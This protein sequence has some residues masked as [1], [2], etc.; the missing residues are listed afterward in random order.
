[1]KL[2]IFLVL[3]ALLLAFNS[4]SFSQTMNSVTPT[5]S[6]VTT[7]TTGYNINITTTLTIP[8]GGY[9]DIDLSAPDVNISL[10]NGK[11]VTGTFAGTITSV[12]GD[13]VRIHITSQ[14]TAGTYNI[15]LPDYIINGTA[16]NDSNVDWT[17][18]GTDGITVIES[19]VAAG[20]FDITDHVDDSKSGFSNTQ[21]SFTTD[22]FAKI[23]G[24]TGAVLPALVA[25]DYVDITFPAGFDVSSLA[26]TQTGGTA[27]KYIG[28]AVQVNGQIVRAILANAFAPADNDFLLLSRKII[29]PPTVTTYTIKVRVYDVSAGYYVG[30]GNF[31]V[32][33]IAPYNVLNFI[34][35][36]A[37]GDAVAFGD[38]D[39]LRGAT[40]NGE[41]YFDL[42]THFEIPGNGTGA[43]DYKLKLTFPNGFVLADGAIISAG[44]EFQEGATDADATGQVYT[45]VENNEDLAIGTHAIEL[46]DIVDYPKKPGTY[47][48]QTAIYVDTLGSDVLIEEGS[49]LFTVY[50][51][52]GI[53]AGTAGNDSINGK[54]IKL[55]SY[56]EGATNVKYTF[57]LDLSQA[58]ISDGQI[59]ITFPAAAYINDFADVFG[60]DEV[61]E[62]DF[63]GAG[64]AQEG[65]IG[66]TVLTIDLTDI[67]GIGPGRKQLILP[68][69]TDNGAASGVI[70]MYIRVD[71]LGAD[72]NYE[73]FGKGTF[74]LTEPLTISSSSDYQ[75]A[76]AI[77]TFSMSSVADLSSGDYA[78]VMFPFE[79]N[80]GSLDG[81]TAT[82]TY[83]GAITAENDT[84]LRITIS[85][86]PS[87]GANTINLPLGVQNPADTSSYF[88]TIMTEDSDSLQ[89][90]MFG[91]N[92]QITASPTGELE[93]TGI[94]PTSNLISTAN[95]SYTITVSTRIDLPVNS[96]IEIKFPSGYS[97]FS[98]L[99]RGTITDAGSEFK[100]MITIVDSSSSEVIVRMKLNEEVAAGNND[101]I[102]PSGIVNPGAAGTYSISMRTLNSSYVELERYGSRSVSVTADPTSFLLS[103]ISASSAVAGA[104]NVTYTLNFVTQFPVQSANPDSIQVIFPFGFRIS[105]AGKGVSQFA[106]GDVNP[107]KVSGDSMLSFEAIS[108]ISSGQ[109]I[110]KITGIT[111]PIKTGTYTIKV[112]TIDEAGI[113][114]ESNP[115]VASNTITM[116]FTGQTVSASFQLDST[117]T[118]LQGESF[119]FKFK[120]AYSPGF[121]GSAGWS[122]WMHTDSDLLAI[123][124]SNG[125]IRITSGLSTGSGSSSLQTTPVTADTKILAEGVPYYLYATLPAS[126]PY[127]DSTKVAVSSQA[128]TVR[129]QPIVDVAAKPIEPIVNA[130]LNSGTATPSNTYTI[131]WKAVDYNNSSIDVKL[132]LAAADSLGKSQITQSNSVVT[133]LASA[134]RI[135][136]DAAI[137]K[138]TASYTLN[139]TSPSIISRGTYYVYITVHDG[140]NYNI[141]RSAGTLIVKHA[142]AIS[143]DNPGSTGAEVDTIKTNDQLAVPIFWGT[144]G[145][146]DV[147]N[148]EPSISLYLSTTNT[149]DYSTLTGHESTITLTSNISLDQ[150]VKNSKSSTLFTMRLDFLKESGNLPTEGTEY[151]VYAVISD[152]TDYVLSQSETKLIFTYTPSFKFKA[153]FGGSAA[154]AAKTALGDDRIKLRKG[155]K[156]QVDFEAYDLDAD[157]QIRLVAC[158]ISNL[159]AEDF[160][161][162]FGGAYSYGASSWLINSTDGT[163]GIGP[164]DPNTI[165]LTTNDSSYVWDTGNMTGIVDGNYYIYALVTND[166]SPYEWSEDSTEV[167]V[168]G[169]T[170]NL[171]G[172][173]GVGSPPSF[174][175]ALSPNVVAVTEGEIITF[176]VA[177]NTAGASANE[178]SFFINIDDSLFTVLDSDNKPFIYTDATFLD[179]VAALKDTMYQTSNATYLG[180]RKFRVAGGEIAADDIV[181]SFKVQAKGNSLIRA[182]DHSVSFVQDASADRV[183]QLS[184][185]GITLPLLLPSPALKVRTLPMARIAGNVPLEGRTDFTSKATI[186]LRETGSYDAISDELY[187]SSNDVDAT[188]EGVQVNT[189][190][191]G[192]FELIN[193]PPSEYS[194]VSFVTNYLTGQARGI[195]VVPGDLY[196]GANPVW[197]DDNELGG[198][199]NYLELRGGDV[200]SGNEVG[201]PDNVV[202]SDD[203]Q[204]LQNNF[205]SVT[206]EG[207]LGDIDG[208]SD[209]DFRDFLITA[210][211]VGEEGVEPTFNKESGRDNSSAAIKLAGIPEMVSAGAEFELVIRI[212]NVSDL[213]GYMFT[214]I[215][216]RNMVELAGDDALTEGDFLYSGDASARSSFF[217]IDDRK[218]LIIVNSLLGKPRTAEGSG[219]IM[220][221]RFRAIADSPHPDIRLAD[222]QLAN[223]VYEITFI[224]SVADV[225]TDFALM[226]NYP[227]PFNPETKI[228]FNI[229]EASR[230]V[231]KIYNILGQEVRTMVNGQMPAG[232]HNLIWDG[233]NNA[234]VRVA[235]GVYIY[236]IKSGKFTAVKKMVMIK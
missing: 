20:V 146:Y 126:P 183:T 129:H 197:G 59:E 214:L 168:S 18:Y 188:T 191:S 219:E 134:V 36:E 233:R 12:A 69:L 178:I 64:I 56:Q 177:V 110:L 6:N 153:S 151:F 98:N 87:A 231:L 45:L 78:I 224:N 1:M 217:T 65:G 5:I 2:R 42:N 24:G 119:N 213:K 89:Q 58:V 9:I 77:Y 190:S 41:F 105:S 137:T 234:G 174:S 166:A 140:T 196:T 167:F 160:D 185:N 123:D 210:G 51:N 40:T 66:T 62:G 206:N 176:D 30:G 37:P 116:T 25:G 80:A 95:T 93:I 35:I 50:R 202:D 198:P 220:S 155:D 70:P 109:Q 204:Y 147:D 48:I 149:T 221:V 68:A 122:L 163:K 83:G 21:R 49:A 111:N 112:R 159:N 44:T 225:P 92:E 11:A 84:T 182:V 229:P 102:L 181:A 170:I 236:R 218:G 31:D 158:Q 81:M 4:I 142:P 131:E 34:S 104:A 157:Q 152:G 88:I 150:A 172:A 97:G 133:A 125:G 165:T 179:D 71:P 33:T 67:G 46:A 54:R 16:G 145:A 228:R 19:P 209:I 76:T 118:D 215:Y 47:S 223:S 57:E 53:L 60:T 10:L 135:G 161:P 154:K 169:S 227:N 200:S 148:A 106:S 17:S 186:E 85:G 86:N 22:M 138:N 52:M 15:D 187:I 113:L 94:T 128:F 101:V 73:Q 100:G 132:W 63:A 141:A 8:A 173:T 156:F 39:S 144:S 55:D 199:F 136:T 38:A 143:L 91:A 171:S 107:P 124:S 103:S 121:S 226:Q 27:V 99:D 127:G 26:S 164:T 230:V 162:S 208:D 28:A 75:D 79:F 195:S 193:V 212:E 7:D 117:A 130:T 32:T 114:L 115:S 90:D 139:I 29:N 3:V 61:L 23:D 14:I 205:G 235:S 222:V 207:D 192:A 194:L 120:A 203:I 72:A 74:D 216:D 108:D 96:F 184:E 201:V 82:G 232:Y 13:I 211:N 175:I 180:F 189:N 43:V